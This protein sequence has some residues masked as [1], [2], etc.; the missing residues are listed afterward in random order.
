MKSRFILGRRKMSDG[1]GVLRQKMQA[2]TGEA[3]SKELG[4]R[5]GKLAVAQG[6]CQAM[7]AA[8]LQM[9]MRS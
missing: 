5:H 2:G 8:Q 4:L 3:V 6:N 9:N 1:G 7:G